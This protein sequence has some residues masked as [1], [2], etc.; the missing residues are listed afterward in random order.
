MSA[1]NADIVT[2]LARVRDNPSRLVISGLID[3]DDCASAQ[4]RHD[5]WPRTNV[6]EALVDEIASP[7]LDH[8]KSPGLV[9]T[10]GQLAAWKRDGASWDHDVVPVVKALCAKSKTPIASWKFFSPAVAQSIADNRAALAIP[11][12]RQ[13]TG[14]PG[15]SITERISA[16]NAE[17]RRRAFEL[18]DQRAAKNG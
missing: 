4:D 11:E 16:E 17:A 9:Q 1:D 6:V 8:R 7:R 10:S 5:D 15:Q 13:A 2:P 18:M 14:P 12:A 3:D